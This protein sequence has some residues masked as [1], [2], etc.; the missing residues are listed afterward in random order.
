MGDGRPLPNVRENR[1]DVGFRETM[2]A[3]H[4]VACKWGYCSL[5]RE[6]PDCNFTIIELLNHQ[7]FHPRLHLD[8]RSTAKAMQLNQTEN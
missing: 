2:C 1:V 3:S 4:K 6:A 8:A 5:S 7:D